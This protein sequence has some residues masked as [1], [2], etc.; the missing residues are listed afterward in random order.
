MLLNSNSADKLGA[1]VCGIFS[2]R[3]MYDTRPGYNFVIRVRNITKF[4][5]ISFVSC[6]DLLDHWTFRV[7]DTSYIELFSTSEV[8]VFSFTEVD[9]VA[10]LATHS[11]LLRSSFFHSSFA[12]HVD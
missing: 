11:L 9:M 10:R 2:M 1:G 7:L 3:S 8:D 4:K 6:I 5:I 12:G